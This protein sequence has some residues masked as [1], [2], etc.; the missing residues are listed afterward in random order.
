[1]SFI[2]FFTIYKT[3]VIS[4]IFLS[5]LRINAHREVYELITGEQCE[6]SEWI[7]H[8]AIQKKHSSNIKYFYVYSSN[9]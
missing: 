7:K 9:M 6:E 8:A 4:L 2:F 1:M 3:F 5:I